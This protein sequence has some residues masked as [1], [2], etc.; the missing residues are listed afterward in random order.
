MRWFGRERGQQQRP[1]GDP[2]DRLIH[3]GPH[4]TG[5][6]TIQSA[7]HKNRDELARRGMHYL[8]PA[9]QPT[10]AVKAL[11]GAI[12]PAR[13]EDG[14]R[15]WQA[16][17]DEARDSGAAQIV[18]SSEFLCEADDQAAARVVS[19]LGGERPRVVVTLRPLSKIVP[20]QWQQF[21]QSGVTMTFEEWLDAVLSRADVPTV[22]L[23]WKRHRHDELVRRWASV[24]GP[25][26]VTVIAGDSSDPEQLPREF[27]RLLG[28]PEGVL[29]PAA[30]VTNRSLTWEEAEA[31]RHF[32]LQ[33][34]AINKKRKR[35]GKE[36]LTLSMDQRLAAWR[37]VK[38]RKPGAEEHRISLPASVADRVAAL[39]T[40]IADSI[41]ASGVQVVGDPAVL[42]Q[43][44]PAASLS[45]APPQTIPSGLGARLAVGLLL[46]FQDREGS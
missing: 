19:D 27:S 18:L 1:L 16:L 3:V 28:L 38:R 12:A 31:I 43:T 29:V 44:P 37:H 35:E 13:R 7:F 22:D 24:V 9:L 11:T 10:D 23:F 20:S 33:F 32:N 34:A 2:P 17:L 45:D 42:T 15:Q 41:V 6:T 5:T 8:G 39:S 25:D 26:N 30:A 14:L 21:V 40:E 36:P 46:Q 4:K